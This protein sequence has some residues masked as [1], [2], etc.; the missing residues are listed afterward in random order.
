MVKKFFTSLILIFVFSLFC[1]P[2]LA[3]EN[4]N[5]K[6]GIHVFDESDLKDAAALVNSSG[7]EWGYVTMVIREDE[8]D[9]QRWQNVFNEMR[10]LKLIPI[11]RIATGMENNYW[12]VPENSE[13][14]SWAEFFHA[15][16]WPTKERLVILFNE[17]NHAKEWGGNIRPDE[18]AETYSLYR[19]T[20]LRFSND[21]VVL[22]AAMDL[23]ASDTSNTM[24]ATRFYEL[25]HAQDTFIFTKYDVL[26]SHSYP[27]PGFSGDVDD[28][29]RRS[30]RGYEWE[31]NY[32]E[33]FG[34]NPE[35]DVYI[36]ETGWILKSDFEALSEDYRKAFEEVWADNRIKAVTPFIL[37]YLG[38]PFENFS[39][40]STKTGEYYPHYARVQS[41][42]K[43]KG[44]PEQIHSIEEATH[45]IAGELVRDSNYSFT[46][47]LKNNGQSIWNRVNGFSMQYKSNLPANNVYFSNIPNT[48]PGQVANVQ[49]RLSTKAPLGQYNLQMQLN[50]DGEGV[51]EI[52]ETNFKVRR[53]PRL[54]LLARNWFGDTTTDDYL[55]SVYS[56][57]E[58]VLTFEDINFIDGFAH[59]D[60]V[61]GIIPDREYR[62]ELSKNYS[63]TSKRY[64]VLGEGTIYVDFGRY[65]PI[66]FNNDSKFN[67]KDIIAVVFNP[68][69]ISSQ[70]TLYR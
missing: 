21:F 55:L 25:M 56:N 10:R 19:N 37:S 69:Q 67:Y 46:L 30:V 45:D 70:M 20:L 8:R 17:P 54:T 36:T 63:P 53:V 12:R 41:I 49:V 65:I 9:I 47:K 40:K 4:L 68:L 16:N 3:Q 42:V 6:F 61:F 57:E 1:K 11:M 66:D 28:T 50:H 39:W 13:A 26:N 22:P 48:E 31:L 34:L 32:L 35:V 59:I 64:A 5:N 2:V 14:Q 38:E 7:G 60:G 29:G 18:Y 15:L 44:E 24:D 23:A 58:L 62:L 52:V 33:N 51:G 27:N 43:N